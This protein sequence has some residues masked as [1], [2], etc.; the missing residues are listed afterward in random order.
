MRVLSKRVAL[1]CLLLTLWSALAFATHHHSTA[2]EAAKCTVCLAAH[3][4]SPQ[5]SSTSTQ[6]ILV[7][8]STFR[9]RPVCAKQRLG[10]FALSVRP[11]PNV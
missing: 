4:S 8:V 5:T 10:V 9:Q 7:T 3:S 11:P 6:E 1:F 2:I